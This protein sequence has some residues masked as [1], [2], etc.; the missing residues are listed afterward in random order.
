LGRCVAS[1]GVIYG[2]SADV[3]AFVRLWAFLRLC[4]LSCFGIAWSSGAAF[5]GVTMRY[6]LL[7][8]LCGLLW[9]FVWFGGSF[10]GCGCFRP[11]VELVACPGAFRIFAERS[12]V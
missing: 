10:C 2:V 12:A 11:S 9:W 3:C 4:V 7:G 1:Y 8:A 5:K 6:Q